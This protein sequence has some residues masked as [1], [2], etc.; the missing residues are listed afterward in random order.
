MIGEEIRMGAKGFRIVSVVILILGVFSL[1]VCLAAAW[2]GGRL[3]AQGRLNM[4]QT[5]WIGSLV[6]SFVGAGLALAAGILG[7]RLAGKERGAA[8]C[9][10]VGAV[11]LVFQVVSSAINLLSGDRSVESV[12]SMG[13]CVL[14]TVLY[15]IGIFSVRASSSISKK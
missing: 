6:L 3:M 7:L 13:L 11:L 8:A 1:L 5:D 4:S 2:G 14:L 15:L 9:K 10:A 12:L